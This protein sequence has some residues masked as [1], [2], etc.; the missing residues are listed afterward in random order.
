MRDI[1]HVSDLIRAYEAVIEKI[2][3]VKGRA[4]NIGGGPSNT[5]SIWAEFGPLLK[6][7]RGSPLRVDYGP[8]RPGDQR[9]FIADISRAGR[10]LDWSPRVSPRQG[11]EALYHWVVANQPL[12]N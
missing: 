8:W 3:T 5:L 7:L 12:F 11:V 6:E 10:D 2:D 9:V 4:F 1:L